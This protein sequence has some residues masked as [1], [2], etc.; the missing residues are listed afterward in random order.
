[1][2]KQFIKPNNAYTGFGHKIFLM[3]YTATGIKTCCIISEK[4]TSE[5]LKT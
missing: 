1:M 3:F 2:G 4:I 5:R